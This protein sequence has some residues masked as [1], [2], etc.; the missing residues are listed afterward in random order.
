LIKRCKQ[1]TTQ[2]G[3]SEAVQH[4]SDCNFATSVTFFLSHV[5]LD[6]IT[7]GVCVSVVI[8]SPWFQMC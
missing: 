4:H 2:P 8:L 3:S 1:Q 6:W 7:L 5:F